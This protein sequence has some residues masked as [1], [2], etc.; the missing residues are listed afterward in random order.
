MLLRGARRA[1]ELMKLSNDGI[2][3]S[4]L[5]DLE[6]CFPRHRGIVRE[7]QVQRWPQG[8]PY[9]FPGRAALQ[10]ALPRDLGRIHLGGDDLEFPC[11]MPQSRPRRKRLQKSIMRGR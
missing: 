5:A 11:M 3:S 9:S 7:I 8:A 1:T 4:F 10:P 2:A 6:K